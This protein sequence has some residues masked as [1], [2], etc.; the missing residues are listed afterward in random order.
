M[1]LKETLFTKV[2]KALSLCQYPSIIQ[3][4][5]FSKKN[6][7][8][9]IYLAEAQNGSLHSFL[10]NNLK[11]NQ[12]NP[13][14]NNTSKFII[15]YGIAK[16][17]HYLSYHKIMNRNLNS[18]N[19]LLDDRF[20]PF[21]TNFYEDVQLFNL[22]ESK[23]IA[24][25]V[26]EGPQGCLPYAGIY[27]YGMFL[28][29]LWTEIP[30]F[31]H[32]KSTN[33]VFKVAQEGHLPLIPSY[34]NVNI[35]KLIENCLS[36]NP[37]SRPNFDEIISEFETDKYYTDDMDKTA[38]EEYKKIFSHPS[39]FKFKYSNKVSENESKTEQ[40]QDKE[41]PILIKL[42][43]ASQAG[44]NASQ[45]ILAVA[46]FEGL[47][48]HPDYDESF[49]YSMMYIKKNNDS[50][51]EPTMLFYAANSCVHLGDYKK[52]GKLMLKSANG[53][54]G[55]A[56]FLLAELMSEN[57]VKYRNSDEIK[58]FYRYAVDKGIPEAIKKYAYMI[59][60]N[61]FNDKFSSKSTA[62]GY[63]KRGSEIG[64]PEL[65][66][67]WAVRNERGRDIEQNTKEAMHLMKLAANLGYAP[68]LV[69]YGIHLLNGINIEKNVEEAKYRFH[70]AAAK[71]DPYGQLWYYLMCKNECD[72]NNKNELL[73]DYLI[74]SLNSNKNP[75]SWSVYGKELVQEGKIDEA[76]PF[77]YRGAQKGSINALL[78][79]GQICEK[80]P[81]FGDAH[82]YFH[83]ASNYC[84]CLDV[85]G[86]TSP[87]QYDVYHC[88][89]CSID[90][91]EGCAKH[92]HSNH[93]LT[94]IGPKIGFKCQCGKKGFIDKCTG[95]FVGETF[96][97]QHLYQCETCCLKSDFEYICKSCAEKCHKYHKIVD[98]GV[99][100]NICCCGMKKMPNKFDCHLLKFALNEGNC[101][102][103]KQRQRWF[104]CISCGLYG[105][106]D[107]G[108][109]EACAHVCHNNHAILDLGVL[110]KICTCKYSNCLF[111]KE[112]NISNTTAIEE[113]LL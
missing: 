59:Y 82:F 27:S 79:L 45:F 28:Y 97:Y 101:S 110:D 75:E 8:G 51:Y 2:I 6:N 57:K 73:N 35:R 11:S 76:L 87:I 89:E 80:E 30:P 105:S 90:I 3:F 12:F 34:V 55:E 70:S 38:I 66:Y 67:L 26:I 16:S 83:L 1:Q 69:D 107:I 20:Y 49:K 77:L 91:C 33:L 56:A 102:Q 24:P 53:G 18:N 84:H 25:E 100:R 99:V 52:A 22:T 85:C 48:G 109:C 104:Q 21:L 78:C 103:I 37:L 43:E 61:R 50:F 68:A 32:I 23:F 46:Q 42:K 13:N 17:M 40:L 94:K 10:E 71:N 54:C 36:L 44:D 39:D 31:N 81:K 41:N 106:E 74:M 63:F 7:F 58:Y 60:N 19:V 93:K 108:F 4:I 112:Q 72:I 5:G 9:Y 64:D 29:E 92:C 95:E 88:D 47:F 113:G 15:S 96:C 86:F 98:C 14:F 65:M 62:I 111:E